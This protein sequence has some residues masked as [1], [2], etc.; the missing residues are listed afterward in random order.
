MVVASMLE[1]PGVVLSRL[2]PKGTR[3]RESEMSGIYRRQNRGLEIEVEEVVSFC[4]W[5]GGGS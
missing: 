2:D 4:R 1:L 5:L 3:A